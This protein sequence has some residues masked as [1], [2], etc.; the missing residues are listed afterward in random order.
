MIVKMNNK[1]EKFYD[2]MGRMFGS[3]IV[4]RQTNDRIYDD[5]EKEWYLNLEDDRVVAFVS[6]VNNTIKNVY[7]IKD[8]YLIDILK[9]IRKELKIK[10]SI[11]PN[12][13]KEIYVKAGFN[14]NTMNSLKNFVMI[15][16]K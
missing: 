4:Q 5:N 3:R 7:T 12:L 8:N 6:I 1:E 15:Y 9:T 11:V 14:I 13:Y 16:E 2:Y 10:E